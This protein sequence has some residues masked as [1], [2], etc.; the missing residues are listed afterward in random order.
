MMKPSS[1]EVASMQIRAEFPA[2]ELTA[3]VN[4]PESEARIHAHHTEA[5]GAC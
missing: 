5:I 4:L 3:W 2:E 1:L